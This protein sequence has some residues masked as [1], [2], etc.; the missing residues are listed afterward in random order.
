MNKALGIIKSVFVII[1]NLIKLFP[2]AFS[3]LFS[4]IPY[5]NT[6]LTFLPEL[7]SFIKTLKLNVDRGVTK[8][9]MKSRIKAVSN[10]FEESD[11]I[12]SAKKLRDG[13]T[14]K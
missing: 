9:E 5:L 4:A 2:R 6:V 1:I 12:E 7:I 10:A 13:L 3:K 14:F 11:R 8:I